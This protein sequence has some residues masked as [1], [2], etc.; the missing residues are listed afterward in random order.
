[1]TDDSARRD[2][3]NRFRVCGGV[4]HNAL[5]IAETLDVSPL[6]ARELILRHGNDNATLN[7]EAKKLKLELR[8]H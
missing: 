8:D 2:I 1:M 5:F 6:Q 4:D 7:R 3:H